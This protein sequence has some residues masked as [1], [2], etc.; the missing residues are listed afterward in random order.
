MYVKIYCNNNI[1][2]AFIIYNLDKCSEKHT[3][4]VFEINL[5]KSGRIEIFAYEL[6]YSMIYV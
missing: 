5:G 1:Y 6:C 2:S 4:L 3:C